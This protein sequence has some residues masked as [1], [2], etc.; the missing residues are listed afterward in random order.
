MLRWL[1]I[2]LHRPAFR[3]DPRLHSRSAQ[4][5]RTQ[6][7]QFL[8]FLRDSG[9]RRVNPDRYEQALRRRRAVM[10][11]FTWVAVAGFAWVVIESAQALSMY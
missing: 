10:A 2:M 4:G 6:S 3:A 8:S 11:V 9:F 1:S 5:N 7:S